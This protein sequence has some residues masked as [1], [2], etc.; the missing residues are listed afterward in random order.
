MTT[1]IIITITIIIIIIILT[2]KLWSFILSIRFW[3]I[4]A[5]PIRAMSALH[6]IDAIIN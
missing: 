5:S 1:T 6:T 2:T 3:P 4:T